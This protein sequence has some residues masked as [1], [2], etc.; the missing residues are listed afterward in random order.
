MNRPSIPAIVMQHVE[1]AAHLRHVRS[2]LVRAPHVRLLHLG[3]LDERVAAHL[4]GVAVAGAYGTALARQALE[5]PGAGEI[6]VA[7]VRAIED[8]DAERLD[9]LLA[10]A[11]ALPSSRAGLLSAFGWTNAAALRGIAKPLL[12]AAQPWRREVALAACAMH[13]VDPGV[14]LARALR[15]DDASLRARAWRVAGRCGRRDLVDACLAALAD[16]DE[17]CA[18]EA[19]RSALLLGDRTE[20]LRS[21][22]ALAVGAGGVNPSNLAALCLVLKVVSPKDAQ[23]MLASLAQDPTQIRTMIRGIAVAGDPHYVPWLIAQMEDLKL[24]RLAGEAF[25]FIT[26]LDLAYLDLD[27]KPPEGVDFGPNDDPDDAN[28]AMD[29]DD[30]L[31]WPDPSKIAGWWR[32]NGVRFASGTRYFMGEV[33][34]PASCL[35][36][37]KTGF[38]GQRSAAAE[39]LSLFMPGTPLFNIAAPTWRQRRLLAN[40]TA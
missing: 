12:E 2:V 35:E 10:I 4:D 8:H 31:P 3:R 17:R 13:A 24:A 26:G 40:M 19:A 11:E 1:E 21:V 5:R 16:A 38:Q 28:V 36:V 22:K 29:E 6:F 25:S 34:T 18:F 30:S 23:G 7:T 15:D 14:A 20:S 9:E 37:L 33:P 39:Y 27:R 32:A